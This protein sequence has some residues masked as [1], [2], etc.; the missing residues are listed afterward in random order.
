[1]TCSTS[2]CLVTVSGIHEMYVC[3]YVEHG[4]VC[5]FGIGQ[6]KHWLQSVT[7]F[8]AGDEKMGTDFED[9]IVFT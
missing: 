5:N 3:M 2:C 6:S 1:M 4:S 9:Y 7:I 8:A